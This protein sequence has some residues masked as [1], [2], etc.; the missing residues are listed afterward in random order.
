MYI[1]KL[2][3]L[4]NSRK[5]PSGRC[6]AGKEL[7][8]GAAG[9]WIRP[10]STR[11]GHEVSE[12]ERRY[13][14]GMKAQLLDIVSVPLDHPSPQGHQIENH[15]LDADYYWVK[16]GTA[17]WAQVVAAVDGYDAAFWSHSQSTYHGT[18]DKVAAIDTPKIGGSLRLVRV[19]DLKVRVRSEDGYEGNPSRR[20]VRAS[21]TIRGDFYVLSMTDPAIE[22]E[23]LQKED[24]TYDI[25][26]AVICV[27]LVEVWNGFAFRVVASVITSE[28]CEA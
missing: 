2:I 12:E 14:T 22:E 21:F 27:S 13:Q 10:V 3:C 24:G 17:T 19:N 25:G 4:A 5:P 8:D 16:H 26:D 18:N 23:Y 15:V 28:R 11:P 6:I 20:R 1:R 7:D 9:A